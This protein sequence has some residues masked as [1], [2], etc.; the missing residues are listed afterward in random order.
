MIGL[1]LE[2]IVESADALPKLPDTTLQLIRVVNDPDSTIDQMVDIIRYDQTVTTELLR[3][4]NS[5]Y[6]GLSRTITSI[7]DAVRYVGTA[8]LMQLV[9]AAHTQALMRPEQHGYGLPPG[10][11]WN[12]SI[13]VAVG[14]RLIGHDKALGNEGTLF[15]IGLLHDV[16]KI[17]LNE[18][19]GAAYNRIVRMVNESRISFVESERR[20]LGVTHPEVGELVARR[21]K[22][23]DPIP[24]CIRYHHEPSALSEPNVLVDVVHLA[25]SACLLMGIGGGDDSPMYVV[26]AGA[27][28]RI[29]LTENDIERLGAAIVVEVKSIRNMFGME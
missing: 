17:M 1:Q 23:P 28:E 15:T 21:W 24:D 12:H 11:L 14:S 18:H 26:D 8:K 9:T 10:A 3:L 13:G 19:I 16:G 5:A 22:L 7:D 6:F 25:D 29:G 27:I 20:L 4:C 2:A